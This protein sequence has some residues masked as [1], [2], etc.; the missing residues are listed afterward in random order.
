MVESLTNVLVPVLSGGTVLYLIVDKVF[1]RKKD[2]A[3]AHSS[4]VASFEKE[5]QVIRKIHLDF[6]DDVAK[7]KEELQID[8][9]NSARSHVREI[10]DFREQIS[11][12]RKQ[13]LKSQEQSAKV[14]EQSSK[15]LLQLNETIQGQNDQIAKM[16]TYLHLLC[17]KDCAERHV[18]NC[19]L[20]Q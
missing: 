16:N 13:L 14:I 9:D 20:I 7:A 6:L 10:N 5:M 17:D 19:P 2:V 3:D 15:R 8:T 12:L 11:Q 4:E 1:S 18:P